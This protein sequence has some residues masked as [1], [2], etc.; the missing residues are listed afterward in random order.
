S[1]K[2]SDSEEAEASAKA[3]AADE[4]AS[5]QK[6]SA[7]KSSNDKASN[8]KASDEK[9]SGEKASEAIEA[10]DPDLLVADDDD[11][12]GEENKAA[13]EA[14][15]RRYL[16]RR[17]WL[18]ARGFWGKRGGRL[19]WMLP[20]ALTLIIVA[21][22]AVQYGINVWNRAIFDGLERHDAPMVFF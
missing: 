9:V 10:I 12:D 22:V 1:E 4:E 7:E 5:K 16:L 15:R 11:T 18:S 21:N 13:R 17:F 2:T 14:R 20:A 3:S 19:A 8:D 6:A